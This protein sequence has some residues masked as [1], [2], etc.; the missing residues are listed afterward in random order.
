MTV[1]AAV[2]D[3]RRVLV[4]SH[5]CRKSDETPGNKSVIRARLLHRGL[6]VDP[7]TALR[8]LLALGAVL[9]PFAAIVSAVLARRRHASAG[10]PPSS[11]PIVVNVYQS[12]N[13]APREPLNEER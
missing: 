7:D 3:A 11:P 5:A 12:T 4:F 8:W 2:L 1:G 6:E 13:A 10:P 9:S